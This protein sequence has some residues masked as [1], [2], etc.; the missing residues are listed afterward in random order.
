MLLSRPDVR[1]RE[2]RRTEER[3]VRGDGM[4]ELAI[5]HC[6]THLRRTLRRCKFNKG[7][8]HDKELIPSNI[9][10]TKWN[11]DG[12]RGTCRKVNKDLCLP[13]KKTFKP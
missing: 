4:V 9:N 5:V 8:P 6:D 12:Q 7:S 2:G 11:A 13:E 1:R 10:H 3:L